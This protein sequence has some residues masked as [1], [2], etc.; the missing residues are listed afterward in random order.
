M[1]I[2]VNLSNDDETAKG[3]SMRV[4]LLTARM[5]SFGISCDAPRLR[6][7]IRQSPDGGISLILNVTAEMPINT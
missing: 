5:A 4:D 6:E 7:Q 2:S 1:P 3:K